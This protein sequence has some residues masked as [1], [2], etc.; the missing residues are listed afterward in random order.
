MRS[1]GV[2]WLLDL[3]GF[4]VYTLAG[5]YK[6]FR[7][8]ALKKFNC[9]YPLRVVGGYTGSG[10]TDIIG[11]LA[12][13]GEIVIDL[14]AIA[15]HKGSAFGDIE[16]VKQPSQ[17]M[18]ENMLAMSLDIA[19]KNCQLAGKSIWIEDESQRIG[20]V[21]IPGD[22]WRRMR[23]SPLYFFEIPFEHRLQYLV[24]EY[25][26]LPK[27]KLV[28]A[29]MRIQKRLG[30]LDTKLAINYLLEND[31]V[32][33]FDI[34]LSYYDKYYK[35]AQAAR[36]RLSDLLKIVECPTVD[37]TLNLQKLLAEIETNGKRN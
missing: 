6:A 37:S 7:Q 14:E 18:F 25:G 4:K 29:I 20:L 35:K 17:E 33:A 8:W 22:F 21:N 13:L 19:M 3:Y 9:D 26:S 15:R 27:E 31:I 28:T 11:A 2:A 36:D 1:A 32:A 5:G 30:G 23:E 16:G 12:S 24:K 10:K 34:L